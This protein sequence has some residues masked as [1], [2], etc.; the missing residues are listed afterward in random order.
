MG[1]SRR[2]SS[3]RLV[4]SSWIGEKLRHPRTGWN[5]R[6]FPWSWE[7]KIR[8][9]WFSSTDKARLISRHGLLFPTAIACLRSC[10]LSPDSFI[11]GICDAFPQFLSQFRTLS[12]SQNPLHPR[13]SSNSISFFWKFGQRVVSNEISLCAM[14]LSSIKFSSLNTYYI[15]WN[16]PR[17]FF[18]H[19]IFL[20]FSRY[21]SFF[22]RYSLTFDLFAFCSIRC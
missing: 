10:I 9:V 3:H 11:L 1:I 6:G 22:F 18:Y 12:S 5:G 21:P 15:S 20:S 4:S 7:A 16:F 2:N 14:I 17:F 8:C 13:V 19:R